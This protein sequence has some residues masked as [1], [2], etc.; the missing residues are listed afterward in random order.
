MMES[1][2]YPAFG[3]IPRLNRE[4]IW[5]EKIDGTNGMVS[6]EEQPFGMATGVND[7]ADWEEKEG[8]TVVIPPST[9][10]DEDTLDP[11]YEYWV[12]AGSRNRWLT[13]KAD[14]FGFAS[15]VKENAMTL[16][17]VLGPG[18]HYGEWWGRGI[19]RNY[20]LDH[21][22]FS[23]FNVDRWGWLASESGALIPDIGLGVV[24][25]LGST[26]G[27]NE[28]MALNMF[29]V[30]GGKSFAAPGFDKPEGVVGFHTAGRTM[31]KVLIENDNRPKGNNAEG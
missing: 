29:K 15:W 3:K 4:V 25:R 2:E 19:Q 8:I 13:T 23:L 6:V 12:R 10:V 22:R 16:A 30:N 21:R 17:D 20:G 5:T 28:T 24:P 26:T 11:K 31:F 9:E 18:L 14:N 1:G 27:F 7:I